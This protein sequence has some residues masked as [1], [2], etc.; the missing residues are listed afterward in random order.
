MQIM[1]ACMLL[2]GR[3]QETLTMGLRPE[4]AKLWRRADDK[5]TLSLQQLGFYS[6]V[7]KPSEQKLLESKWVLE[8]KRT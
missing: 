3:E 4:V 6:V 8:R 1:D 5:D 2:M 7:N